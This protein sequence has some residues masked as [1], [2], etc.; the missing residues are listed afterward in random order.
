MGAAK[1]SRIITALCP[2]EG[3]GGVLVEHLIFGFGLYDQA[4]SIAQLH[5]LSLAYLELAEQPSPH[6]PTTCDAPSNARRDVFRPRLFARMPQAATRDS[7][8]GRDRRSCRVPFAR[9][10]KP[11][12]M[13]VA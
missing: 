6:A 8:G 10:L 12:R 4:L 1:P 3:R 13:R 5:H 2:M 7:P 9:G 11:T